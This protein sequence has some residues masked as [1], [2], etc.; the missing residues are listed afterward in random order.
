VLLV[1][2]RTDLSFTSYYNKTRYAGLENH[3]SN[4][5]ANSL[6]QVMNYTPLLRNLALQHAATACLSD[7]CLLCELGYVFDMLQKAEG[8]TCQASNM[9]K[10]LGNHPQAAPL[11]LLEEEVHSSTPSVMIQGLTRFLLDRI[12]NDYRSIPPASTTLERNLF[13]LPDPVDQEDLLSRLLATSAVSSIRCNNC[14]NEST[15]PGSTYVNDLIYP[16]PKP[17]GRGGGG[18]NGR[19]VKTTF[20]QVLKTSVE[21]ET[22]SKGWC[23]RCQRYQTLQTRKTIHNIPAV[24]A[25]NAAVQ[26]QEHRRLWAT[27]GWLPE[28]IGVIVDHAGQFFCYEGEDLKLHLQRQMHQVVV[29]SLVGVVVNVEGGEAGARGHLVGMVNGESCFRS[30]SCL[31]HLFLLAGLSLRYSAL[32]ISGRLCRRAKVPSSRGAFIAFCLPVLWGCFTTSL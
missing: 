13:N 11:G 2:V 14:R 9:L 8:S 7:P 21:R 12:S 10:A 28:E 29:Y 18:G 15:R 23:S 20:S 16:Q 19:A 22:T 27:P 31:S 1:G 26:T 6:L 24:L 4:S 3:I 17:A 5:Y 25:L 30:S 32:A